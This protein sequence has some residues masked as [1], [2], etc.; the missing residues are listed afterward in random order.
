MTAPHI[1]NYGI[2]NED[3]E[4]DKIHV[5]GFVIKEESLAPSNWRS[6][7]QIGDY[8]KTIYVFKK[9]FVINYTILLFYYF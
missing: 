1:G 4:S 9:N 2:N 5:K 6:E 7:K 8:L 3:V